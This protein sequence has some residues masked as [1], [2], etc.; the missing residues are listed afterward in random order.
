MKDNSNR[1]DNLIATASVLFIAFVF[2]A[3]IYAFIN[4]FC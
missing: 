3:L 1:Y 4:I 2:G